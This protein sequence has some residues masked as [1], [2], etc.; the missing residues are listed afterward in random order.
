MY[1][2]FFVRYKFWQRELPAV[3]WY[4]F[5]NKMSFWFHTFENFALFGLTYVTS[6][7]YYEVL[8][9]HLLFLLFLLLLLLPLLL[10]LTP[11]LPILMCFA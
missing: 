8:F 9:P 3:P 10:L 7:E 1:N 2:S 4:H 5:W 11:P 6:S